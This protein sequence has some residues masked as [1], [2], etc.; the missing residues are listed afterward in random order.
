M[1]AHDTLS[2]ILADASDTEES[3]QAA[4]HLQ[5]LQGLLKQFDDGDG[6]IGETSQAASSIRPEPK[7]AD[8]RSGVGEAGEAVENLSDEEGRHHPGEAESDQG[9]TPQRLRETQ[10]QLAQMERALQLVQASASQPHIDLTDFQLHSLGPVIPQAMPRALTTLCL[11]GNAFGNMED[12]SRGLSGLRNLRSLDLSSCRLEAL[13]C[14][15]KLALEKLDVSNNFL[16]SS[17]GVARCSQLH[18][19]TFA[20]N[21]LTKTDQIEMLLNLSVLDLSENR[22][23]SRQ[24]LRPLAACSRLESLQIHGNPLSQSKHRAWVASMFPA[25]IWLDEDVLRPQRLRKKGQPGAHPHDRPSLPDR[26][27]Q[28]DVKAS[29]P[30]DTSIEYMEYNCRYARPTISSKMVQASN[31]EAPQ[32]DPKQPK[33]NVKKTT[34]ATSFAGFA[35]AAR[36]RRNNSQPVP[37]RVNQPRPQHLPQKTH[38]CDTR[39]AK[40]AASKCLSGL[41]KDTESA[42]LSASVGMQ[43]RHS[44]LC[45]ELIEE[46]R[47]LLQRV[48]AKLGEGVATAMSARL[49][50]ATADSA[51]VL[52]PQHEDHADIRSLCDSLRHD[53]HRKR[54]LLQQTRLI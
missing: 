39:E 28:T 35:P 26:V 50:T 33:R 11:S 29:Q 17:L 19:L 30:K 53:I 27:Q 4:G 12:L 22:L 44:T 43:T 2:E 37:F 10:F 3:S 14:L 34:S 15:P 5:A 18:H 46:K 25:L 38:Q 16:S 42:A 31:S 49:S 52:A 13:T 54:A 23:N 6:E 48:S 51:G 32:P 47:R 21:R 9:D 45:R 36:P 41:G 20:K 40:T 8:S 24:L 7:I 1:T